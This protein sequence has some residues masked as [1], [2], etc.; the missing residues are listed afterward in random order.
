MWHEANIES[1]QALEKQIE[2]GKEDITELRRARNSLLN[3]STRVPPEILVRIFVWCLTQEAGPSLFHQDFRGLQ[4]DSYNF[5]FVCHHWFE[6]ASRAPELWSF[7]GNTLKD[8]RKCHRHSGVAPVDLVLYGPE[9]DQD[10]LFDGPL[11]DA[12]R[13][14]VMQN[15]IRRVHLMSYS[16]YALTSIISSLAPG[17]E[18]G[19]NDSIESIIWRNERFNCVDVSNFFARSHLS[20]LRILDLTTS[21]HISSW[22]YLAPRTTLLTTLRLEISRFPLLPTPTTS[23]LFSILTSNSNLRELRLSDAAIPDDTDGSTP[24]VSLQ[25]LQILSL[26]GSLRRLVGLLHRLILPQALGEM[27]LT[28]YDPTLENISQILTPYMRDHFRRDTGFQD[29]LEVSSSFSCGFLSISVVGRAQSAMPAPW[30]SLTMAPVDI[31]HPN[32]TEHLFIN[33]IAPVP[34]ESVV[35]FTIDLAVK[36][37]EELLLTMPSIETLSVCNVELSKGFLQPNPEGMHS[38]KK[39]LPS[40]RSLSLGNITVHGGN[41]SHLTTYLAHQTSG[42]QVISLMMFGDYPSIHP[43]VANEIRDLVKVFIYHQS[44]GAEKDE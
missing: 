44:P 28:G 25:D 36:L 32:M 37:S 35:S 4:K 13:S 16:H 42:D 2:E 10:D 31:P 26:T 33:L 12:V 34:R 11:Q 40:L 5:L 39:L 9:C 6:V 3:I 41:W 30:V 19:Q 22:D 14:R 21:F 24:K 17:D 15:T 43:E 23:Q 18:G 7:W 1:I 27:R 20:R 29:T 38:K 8:W